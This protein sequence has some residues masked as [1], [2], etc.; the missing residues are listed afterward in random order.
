MPNNA[1]TFSAAIAATRRPWVAIAPGWRSRLRQSVSVLAVVGLLAACTTQQMRIGADDGSDSCRPLLVALDSTGNYFAED[2]FKGAVVGAVGGALLGAL[3]SGGRGSSIAAG[4]VA[5]GLLG[6]AA[7]YWSA[8]RQQ[9]M[10][11][12]GL[13][14]Q[15]SG[16]LAREN[17][18]IDRTQ[19]AFDRLMDC[20]WSQAQQ[21]RADLRARRITRPEAEAR[22]AQV[23]EWSKRDIE[24]A[25]R[26]NGQI[27]GRSEQFTTAGEEMGSVRKGTVQRQ[28]QRLNSNDRVVRRS[29]LR[30]RPSAGAPK[31]DDVPAN[32]QVRVLSKSGGYA[33]VDT[34]D[35]KRGFI[36]TSALSSGNRGARSATEAQGGTAAPA[37]A[38]DADVRRLHASN[39]ARRDNFADRVEAAEGLASA[40]FELDARTS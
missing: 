23:R 3:V 8:L 18:Q 12:A 6:A 19:Q 32:S 26:I 36:T 1:T 40:G 24:V 22:M 33:L 9:Q 27:Q 28:P 15:V 35:G 25:R 29:E 31:V 20:R 7:G 30:L 38:S 11:Q 37:A 16:D 34:P 10:D 39:I 13:Y 4:A 2:I 14:R 21:I 5:G 17:G